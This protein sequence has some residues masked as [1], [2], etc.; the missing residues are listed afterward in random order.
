MLHE[1]T[2]KRVAIG[3]TGEDIAEKFLKEREYKIIERNVRQKFGEIDI[4]ALDKFGDIHFVEV[5][6]LSA[7]NILEPEDHLTRSK[8]SKMKKMADWYIGQ[9]RKTLKGNYQLD[10]VAI[11]MGNEEDAAEVRFYENLS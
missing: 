7:K 5:K 2:N 6:A 1:N 8:L 11:K 9:N 3:T 4:V 10:L